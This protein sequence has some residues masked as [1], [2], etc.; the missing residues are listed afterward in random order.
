[1]LRRISRTGLASTATVP[2][3][4]EV[5]IDTSANTLRIA[6]GVTAIGSLP[7][8]STTP[9]AGSVGTTALA[10]AAVTAPKIG[11]RT[12]Q[13]KTANYVLALGDENTLIEMNVGSANTVT[14]PT[15]AS[16][17]FPVGTQIDVTQYGAG[18]TTIVAAG[19]VTP[20]S[21]TAGPA[22]QYAL[23]RLVKRATNEWYVW[24]LNG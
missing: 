18:D 3:L 15:N 19:G 5:V 23:Y 2:N 7:A 9:A 24:T 13:T 4:G 14:I 8:L 17:A 22:V 12:V 6:D 10:A 11:P 20:R 21:P 16:V 1:M